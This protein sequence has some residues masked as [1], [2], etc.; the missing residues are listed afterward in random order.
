M[1]MSNI[2]A[3]IR[4][5]IAS[6][7]T[8]E[9][10]EEI[11]EV[12]FIGD[13]IARVIGL[14][15][16][17]A[18]ELVEFENGAYGMAQNLEKN[19]VGVI[20]FGGYENIHEGEPVKRTGRILD[21][22]VGD[23]LIG[24]VVD[25]LGRPIDGLGAIETTKK[26]PVEN[27]A[28]GVMQ[29]QSVK[30]SLPTGL[31]VVDA[32]VPIGKGQREL[33]IGDRKTGK[34]SIAVDTILNQK[35]KDTL[36]IYVAIGQ[37]ESTVKA[38]V[39][40]LKRY[41][42]MEYTTVVSASASQPAPMLYIAPYAG[43]AMGE[44]WMYQGR[45]VLI[46]YDD[47]SKQAAAYREISLLLRR[48]PGREAYPGDVFYLHSRLLER[49]AKLSD[50]LG[51][52]SLTALPIIETQAGDISAYI[53]TN[54]ISITD[55]Q[56]FLE[57]DLFYSGVRPGLSAGLSVSRV[58]GSAQIKAMKKVSGT[59]RIDLASYRELEAFTQFGSDL[60]AATQQKLNRG[61]RTVE[62]LKQD[63][64]QP[65]PI[66]Y[67]V[68]ILFALTHGLL[69]AIPIDRIKSFEKA[70]Y[71]HLESEHRDLLNEIRDQHV[72][73]DEEKFYKVIESFKQIHLFERVQ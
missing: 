20:I 25:A 46:V 43:T 9:Q 44:E 62:V 19:D 22:P 32:L 8:K 38:L 54:V 58:G 67:Q 47:L 64:H 63:V 60:D 2:T 71:Q 72:I 29:R 30:Q 18:G 5:Q 28:P 68:S 42:A 39:E 26:R 7:E 3:R 1:E 53:P 12:S 52:G 41:G 73:S 14:T 10:I 55:G 23:A 33:I 17:M 21:V 6:F 56:I 70:L 4:D 59:L 51:A 48:P 35:G 24:R 50:E 57:S 31:K 66:E 11:G 13:G 16:V 36:C 49:A 34:T 37:K 40:T 65:L 15:N 61:K 69:D 45:D 27:E